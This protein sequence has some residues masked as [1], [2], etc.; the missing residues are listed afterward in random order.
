MAI[1]IADGRFL[2]PALEWCRAPDARTRALAATLAGSIGGF[3]ATDVLTDLLHDP[4]PDVRAG[5]A[6]ALG[7]LGHWPAA[8]TLAERLGDTSWDV[9]RAAALSLSALGAP[10]TLLLRQALS[11]S[12]PFASDMARHVLE[13]PDGRESPGT[14]LVAVA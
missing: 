6:K 12:D 11:A 10:G 9:R 14:R 7:K 3:R 1:G 8:G 13:L 4:D 2:G 5:A